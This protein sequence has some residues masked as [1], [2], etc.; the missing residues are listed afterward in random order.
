M[1]R[2]RWRG[3]FVGTAWQED[4]R[5]L[6]SG[7]GDPTD[8]NRKP[9]SS[10]S[11]QY[12]YEQ[13]HERTGLGRGSSRVNG[14]SWKTWVGSRVRGPA[15]RLRI[16]AL[17]VLA[18]ITLLTLACSRSTNSSHQAA[19]TPPVM[20]ST[21]S[22]MSE[23]PTSATP[24]APPETDAS[25]GP[26]PRELDASTSHSANRPDD[27]L[28]A[29][30][31]LLTDGGDALLAW[32]QHF[33]AESG[34]LGV[35]L[36]GGP[37]LRAQVERP[38]NALQ[39]KQVGMRDCEG[40]LAVW[41]PGARCDTA[42]F[43]I[44]ELSKVGSVRRSDCLEALTRDKLVSACRDGRLAPQRCRQELGEVLDSC[45]RTRR[46]EDCVAAREIAPTFGLAIPPSGPN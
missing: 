13:S 27:A 4:P 6:A 15:S 28:P 17:L 25:A 42:N 36:A 23:P 32:S 9:F 33:P 34:G 26:H 14:D 45:R 40:L 24:S 12:R 30:C 7:P 10:D 16:S 3:R 5:N 8:W 46:H 43:V 2:P 31:G 41:I 38:V 39:L 29:S 19:Q 35:L 37:T 22:P 21:C 20:A 1:K 11:Q 18:P 44:A